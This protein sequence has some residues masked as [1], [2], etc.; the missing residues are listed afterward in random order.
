MNLFLDG[1]DDTNFYFSRIK[2]NPYLYD[3]NFE[4]IDLVEKI[5]YGGLFGVKILNNK[6]NLK[7][8]YNEKKLSNFFIYGKSKNDIISSNNKDFDIYRYSIFL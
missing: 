3:T 2:E 4:Y 8:S 6:G 5:N 7:L 1:G